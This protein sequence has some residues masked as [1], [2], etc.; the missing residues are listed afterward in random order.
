MHCISALSPVYQINADHQPVPA[1]ILH[2]PH[3]L[4][5]STASGTLRHSGQ[6]SKVFQFQQ[7]FWVKKCTCSERSR[8]RIGLNLDLQC[9]DHHLLTYMHQAQENTLLWLDFLCSTPQTGKPK[10]SRK[11][12]MRLAI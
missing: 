3:G 10:I 1:C 6:M 11:L 12:Q 7:D 8:Q 2:M 9:R 4:I 5:T